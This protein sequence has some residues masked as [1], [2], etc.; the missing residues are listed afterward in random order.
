M[1]PVFIET[2]AHLDF[3]QYDGQRENV[4]R[5]ASESGVEKIINIGINL[6][7][8]LASI[9]LAE[10][11]ENIYA[12][13]GI[14]PHD[15]DA[16]AESDIEDIKKLYQHP[17]VVAIGEVGLDFYRNYSR[18]DK[19]R[20]LF[21]MFLDW[22]FELGLPLIIHSRAAEDELLS[23]IKSKARSGW[24]G[25]VHCF[26][27]DEKTADTVLELGFLISFTGNITFKNFRSAP[28][29]RHIPIEKFLLETDC[30]FMAPEPHRG[31]R[32][33]PA[34]IQYVAQ[35]IADMKNISVS[36]V[37]KITSRNARSLFNLETIS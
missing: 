30:P 8:S 25:V 10:E 12:A 26:A 37:S 34:Y 6:E 32:N 27:G 19:Q 17:K 16:A 9:A 18:Q 24:K 11:Y 7:T 23:I 36:E 20:K 29:V 4:V 33:E 14:H 13:V 28:V 15:A 22:S 1:S 3:H 35:K 2:H 21:R 31:K 5:R